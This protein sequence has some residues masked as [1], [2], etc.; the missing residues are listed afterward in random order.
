MNV[1]EVNELSK[2]YPLYKNRKDKVREILSLDGKSYH[3]NFCALQNIS[4]SV[5]KGS[6]LV[7]LA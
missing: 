7:L 2:T 5:E 6:A 1:I 4:F 3:T